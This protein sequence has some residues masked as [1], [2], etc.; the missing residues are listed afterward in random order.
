MIVVS[1][2]IAVSGRIVAGGGMGSAG[3]F[4]NLRM[5]TNARF[6]AWFVSGYLVAY[7][8]LL[9]LGA[10]FWREF[11]IGMFCCSPVFVAWMAYVVIR[12]GKHGEK[13]LAEGEEFGYG[14]RSRETLGVW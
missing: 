11:A 2:E 9:W 8:I 4:V 14:D 7:C 10:G 12:F 6:A 5:I 13:E 3:E 1:G